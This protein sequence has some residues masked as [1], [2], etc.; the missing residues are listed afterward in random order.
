MWMR[1][2]ARVRRHDDG[3]QL[4][5][6]YLAD[7]TES[8]AVSEELLR[9]KEG[10]EAANR[11]KSD[12]LANMSHEIRTP[13]NGIIGMTELALQT[14][15]TDEQRDH[16]GIVRSSA[17]SLL[18]IINDILDFSKIEAGKLLIERIPYHLGRTGGDSLK[19]LSQ[20]ASGKGLELICDVSA[21]VP[22]MVI[23]DPGRLRQVL[24]NLVGNAIKFT[25][26][27][28]VHVQLRC[29][30]DRLSFQ[31]IDTG[32]GIPSEK[33]NAIFQAFSQED[34]SITRRYG[35]TGLGLTISARLVDAMG[36]HL[37]VRSELGLGSNFFFDLPLV[38]DRHAT[39]PDTTVGSLKGLR[40]LLA[41]D[42]QVN[43]QVLSSMLD[44]FGAIVTA[45]ESG[46]AVL[47]HLGSEKHALVLLDA[48]MP[49]LDGYS[50]AEA[51]SNATTHDCTPLVMLS[52]GAV[53]GDAARSYQ[54]GV[55]AYLPKP[56]T[57]D[58]LL[59]VLLRVLQ[60]S[61]PDRRALI[62]RHSVN[63][64]THSLQILL[65]EDHPVNQQLATSLLTRW[66]HQVTVAD[67][68]QIALDLLAKQR[69]DLVLM[70]M[71][72]PVLDGLQTTMRFRAMEQGRRTPVIAMTAKAMQEDREQ[73]LSA[74]MDDYISKPIDVAEFQRMVQR[75]VPNSAGA[76]APIVATPVLPP[77]AEWRRFD[78]EHGLTQ[79]DQQVVDIICKIFLSQWPLD[80][81]RLYDALKRGDLE[82]IH[83]T[84]HST[85]STMRM[86]GAEPLSTLA[87]VVEEQSGQGKLEGLELLLDALCEGVHQLIEVL[88]RRKA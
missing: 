55:H 35:G 28:Q 69:F 31:V 54:S 75:Y 49:G 20:A 87:A 71:M 74:G 16:L 77:T 81:G 80:E 6:G 67:N 21:E 45:V 88:K 41:D 46:E 61:Q 85:K 58:E 84:A 29:S 60:P 13:M 34:G 86:F 78:F 83:I 27:G 48:Q 53:P 26:Q 33:L 36:G 47:A 73:C 50:T 23:G 22:M 66:G 14:E 79:V 7:V 65:A 51:I 32:I 18:R 57:R 9:A 76:N 15:L 82:T 70:D 10:A 59:K 42:N 64:E 39:Q 44:S 5:N 43:R 30:K 19:T 4:F 72:M 25:N 37:G 52:S 12:F 1:G 11:A 17:E 24:I 56:F 63:D 40:V 3:G 8:R 62:T 68:G 2:E 38:L